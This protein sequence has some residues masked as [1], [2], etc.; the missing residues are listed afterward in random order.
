M[1]ILDHLL[2]ELRA[3]KGPISTSDLARRLEVSESALDGMMSVLV[4]T[5]QLRGDEPQGD[6]YACSGVA[7]GTK[8]VGLEDCAFI[9]SVPSTVALVLEPVAR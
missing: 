6:T 9:V 7:C 8:C 2:A 3:A 1:T 4:A 5:G